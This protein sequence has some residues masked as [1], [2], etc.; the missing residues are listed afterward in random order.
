MEQTVLETGVDAFTRSHY[1]LQHIHA[2]ITIFMPV[3]YSAFDI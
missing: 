1:H 3:L 2:Y